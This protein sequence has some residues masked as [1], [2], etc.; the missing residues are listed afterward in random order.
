M[1]TRKTPAK[2]APAK[3][4]PEVAGKVTA[5]TTLKVGDKTYT[6]ESELPQD[7]MNTYALGH[8]MKEQRIKLHKEVYGR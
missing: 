8:L 5:T 7:R 1:T 3:E 2:K 4:T 6:V